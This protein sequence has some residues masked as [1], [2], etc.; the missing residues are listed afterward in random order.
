MAR[1]IYALEGVKMEKARIGLIRVLTTDD[2]QVLGLHGHLIMNYF[3]GLEVITSCIAGQPRGVFD[4]ATEEQAWPKVV[5]LAQ[6]MAQDGLQAI[7]V[8]CA[9]DPGVQQ[10]REVLDIPIIGAG[11]AAAH[12]ALSLSAS[13]AALGITEDVP[14]AMA[15]V[16][17]S[18]LLASAKPVGVETTVD[19]MKPPGKQAVL[20]AAEKL[21]EKGAQVL[22]LA[23]TGMSTI[24]VAEDIRRELGIRVV[25]PVI[26]T[27]LIAW[28]VSREA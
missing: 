5:A 28:Y 2:P 26:A 22:V 17:G 3:P 16:L 15:N 18:A 24:G 1:T 6:E 9:A 14:A 12:V 21:R 8:S 23:C 7:I 11:S 13:V 10:A 25:D 19:L 20:T 27:G 4:Q